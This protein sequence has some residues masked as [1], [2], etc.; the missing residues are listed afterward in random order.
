MQ[1][2]LSYINTSDGSTFRSTSVLAT[3]S[4]DATSGG[5]NSV[6]VT[7]STEG[8]PNGTKLYWST[9]GSINAN[10]FT[11][12][13]TNGFRIVKNNTA[14]ITRSIKNNPSSTDP[15]S[16]NIQ[17]LDSS[18][19]NVL[20]I[21]RPAVIND[22][23]LSSLSENTKQYVLYGN[24][25]VPPITPTALSVNPATVTA[26]VSSVD[27]GYA[28]SFTVSTSGLSNGTYYWDLTSD[29][30][31][32]SSRLVGLASSGS[33]TLT[34]N[35]GTINITPLINFAVDGLASFG[36][37]VRQSSVTGAIL[38]TSTQILVNDTSTTVPTISAST[39]S[40][41]EGVSVT[42]TV[43]SSGIPNG[44]VLYW[45]TSGTTNAADFT[46]NTTTGSFT[47]TNNSGT[48]TRTLKNDHIVEGNETVILSVKIGSTSG[49]TV[50]TSSAVTVNDTSVLPTYS[51]SPNTDTLNEGESV[52]FN[53]STTD[54]DDG[55]TL[56]WSTGGTTVAAD[57]S[58][59]ASSG[60]FTVTGNSGSVTRTLKN[61]HVTE[62][63]QTVIFY[64]RTGSTGGT[65]VATASTVTVND[66][67]LSPTYSVSPNTTSV[68]EGDDVTFDITTTEIDDGTTLY[69][70]NSGSTNAADFTDNTN[71]GSFTINGNSGS[72][73]K[74]LSADK[75][76]EGSQTI[77]FQIR[78]TSTSG[79]IVATSSTV[80]VNDTSRTPTYSVSPST[81]SVNEGSTVT[82][83]ISTTYVDDGTTL[84]WSNDGTTNSSDFTNGE[85]N[86][87]FD[88]NGNSG[89]VTLEL[90]NDATTEGSQTIIFKVRT[91]STSGTVVA[92]AST[93]TVNDTSITPATFTATYLIVAGGGGGGGGASLG[94]ASAYQFGA[95][96]GGGGGVVTGS[97]FFD[98]ADYTITVGGGGTG[99]QVGYFDRR[100]TN[101]NDSVIDG[102]GVNVSS[103]GGGGGG[104]GD[105]LGNGWDT[106]FDGGSGGGAASGGNGGSGTSGQGNN[107]GS[108]S[109]ARYGGGG[110]GANSAG[111][112]AGSSSNGSGGSGRSVS[113][114][115]GTYGAGGSGG[116]SGQASASTGAANTGNGGQGW[117]GASISVRG[118]GGGSGIVII[119]YNSS[120]QLATGGTVTSAGGVWQHRFTTSGTLALN[121]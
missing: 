67:S 78:T 101:G 47:I 74:T 75:T 107:G 113:P 114:F 35:T 85:N 68:N 56:Y 23:S 1:A 80:T 118:G 121:R 89:S 108:S 34:N 70:T 30:L 96:G 6:I 110:G 81:T 83:N 59:N 14:I 33:F 71:S 25:V 26:N 42:F 104:G 13:L 49:T 95:G 112:N 41:D 19:G 105:S 60:S 115:S 82:F 97:A 52:T 39:A 29:S 57:F 58:D 12:N 73:T 117:G 61:D 11:D 120:I 53:V 90:S 27:E 46:D 66:T 9:V 86:G 76:T 106:G 116:G 28:V 77:I 21:A 98:T 50:A 84:Y 4:A 102:P 31:L 92:T 103:T 16:F 18:G 15:T 111:S 109:Y 99:G 20:T 36:I 55:A 100:A 94:P 69:W 62:G 93:V 54:V 32:T 65:I 119:R 91:G 45:S 37:N 87:S 24:V 51:V 8:Y 72:V 5:N 79:S 88:I 38:G 3:T 48:I 22:I 40:V 7:L 63:S 17:V 64:V 10:T 44:T 43:T 2:N